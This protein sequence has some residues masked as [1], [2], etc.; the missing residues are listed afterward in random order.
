M[1]WSDSGELC[2][3]ATEDT[4]Y[5][6]KYNPEKVTEAMENK[7]DIGEDGI[8]EAFDVSQSLLLLVIICKFSTINFLGK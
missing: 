8:E 5:I 6:L 2:A 4:I 1:Y 7:D 3:I